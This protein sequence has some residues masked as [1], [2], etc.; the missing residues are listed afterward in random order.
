[1]IARGRLR[2]EIGA[3]PTINCN[4]PSGDQLVTMSP[5]TYAS[6][7]EETVEAHI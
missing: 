7:C 3:H 4:T 6:R 1:V 5:R 2:A